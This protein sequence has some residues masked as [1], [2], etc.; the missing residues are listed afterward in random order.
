MH[1][2]TNALILALILGTAGVAGA[3]DSARHQPPPPS[4]PG[5]WFTT[6]DGCSYSRG[7]APG[8]PPTWHLIQNPH[9]IGQ[10]NPHRGCPASLGT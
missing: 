7:K 3:R 2:R 5:Q 6:A 8:Y 1:I 4:Y 10:P 9:H